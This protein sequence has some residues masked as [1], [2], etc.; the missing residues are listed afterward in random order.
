MQYDNGFVLY[1]N[2]HELRRVNMPAEEDIEYTTWAGSSTQTSIS[3]TL[4]SSVLPYFNDGE[5][6]M[7]IEV[8]QNAADSSD[9]KFY[10]R[11]IDPD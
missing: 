4:D 7:A 11:L 10:L 9:L 3:L 5:N 8:H 6:V 1:V 2:G